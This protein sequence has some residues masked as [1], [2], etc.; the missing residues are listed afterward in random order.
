MARMP[1]S[2]ISAEYEETRQRQENN[3]TRAA[4]SSIRIPINERRQSL[5]QHAH[6]KFRDFRRTDDIFALSPNTNRDDRGNVRVKGS[7][8]D[9]FRLLRRFQ[10]VALRN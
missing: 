9:S 4:T 2:V 8:E 7:E 5:K 1:Q 10:N 3:N 6:R